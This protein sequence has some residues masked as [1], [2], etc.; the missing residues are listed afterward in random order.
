[1]RKFVRCLMALAVMLVCIC[2]VPMET[3]AEDVLSYGNY[4]YVVNSDGRTV[5]IVEYTG[6]DRS[7]SIPANIYGLGVNEIR[8]FAFSKCTNLEVVTLPTGII[9]VGTYAFSSCKSLKKVDIKYGLN[10][11]E[12]CAF[13]NCANMTQISIPISVANIEKNAFQNCSDSIVISCEN[14][15]IAYKYAVD[16]NISYNIVGAQT[17][18]I[19]ISSKSNNVKITGISGKKYTGYA[20][21]QNNVIVEVNGIVLVEN[22][23]Y[24]QLPFREGLSEK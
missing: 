10:Y 9:G 3:K 17:S 18:S 16:N 19:D 14:N 21:M 8:S 24:K 2:F 5:D 7:I 4:R 12:E 23:D 6:N 1:M 20:V 13:K 11:I 15:S 22:R